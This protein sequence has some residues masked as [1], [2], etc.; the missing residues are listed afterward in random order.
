LGHLAS[1]VFSLGLIP[2]RL[3]F[4]K[5]LRAA[6]NLTPASSKRKQ[7]L[8]YTPI[9]LTI[10]HD[11]L[12]LSDHFDAAVWACLLCGFWSAARLGEL[13]VKTRSDFDRQIHTKRSDVR[14][15]RCQRSGL[16]QTACFIPTTKT[17]PTGEDIFW[18]QQPGVPD[19]GDALKNHLQINPGPGNL[20]AFRIPP[21]Q[22]FEATD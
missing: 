18:S 16:Q 10:V 12:N 19:P 11:H 6:S 15:E 20:R 13:T 5:N 7:R 3:L 4:R 8:P 2:R 17:A 1:T 9:I 14:K 22:P 21:Q